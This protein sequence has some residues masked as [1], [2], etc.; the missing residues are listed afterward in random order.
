MFGIKN[1]LK[2][3]SKKLAD[4]YKKQHKLEES[5]NNSGSKKDREEADRVLT[6]IDSFVEQEY[7]K[8]VFETYKKKK[9]ALLKKKDKSKMTWEEV[10]GDDFESLSKNQRHALVGLVE[11]SGAYELQ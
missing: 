1:K 5:Y 4:L 9:P 10:F 3:H 6:E 7:A 11:G 8:D 2:A